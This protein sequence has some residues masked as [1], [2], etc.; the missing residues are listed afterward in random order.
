MKI[1]H[2][3]RYTEVYSSDPAAA[4]GRIEPILKE[5]EGKYDFVEPQAASGD[6]LRR[7]HTQSHIESIKRDKHVYDIA[8]LA[9]GGAIQAARIAMDGEASFGL[10]RPPGHH[11]SPDHC[12]GFCYFN[13]IAVA[14]ARLQD[15][16]LIENALILDFDLHFGDGS[17]NIFE[18]SKVKY[19]HPEAQEREQFID[20]IAKRFDEEKDYAILAISAGFDRHIEDW[21]GLLTTDDYRTIGCLSKEAAERNC[22]GRR[23]AVLEGGYNHSVLGKNVRAFVEGLA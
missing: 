21:G 12:W 8:C 14:L 16:N 1:V 5:L 10:I 13:N 11:A 6:D 7:V 15:E 23:F 19:F 9:A 3:P 17:H 18:G 2:H 20:Q 22:K 4:S